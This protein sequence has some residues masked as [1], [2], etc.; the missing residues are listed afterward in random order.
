M[1]PPEAVLSAPVETRRRAR[2]LIIAAVL[3]GLVLRLAFTF[4]YWVGKPLTL[5]EQEYLLLASNAARGEGLTYPDAGEQ[6]LSRHFERP[7]VFS[8]L[9][10]A[11][12]R[13]T[14][15]PLVSAPRGDSG[16]PRG[17]PR[18]SSEV[19]VSVKLVQSL[20]GVAVIVLIAAL[21]GRAAGSGGAVAG[22]TLAAVYP[23]MVWLSGYVLSEAL[24]SALALGVVWLLHCAPRHDS[25][26]GRAPGHALDAAAGSDAG[27]TRASSRGVFAAG[28]LAGVAVL[29]KEHLVFF[30]PFAGFWLLMR[31]GL[32]PALVLT[33]GVALVLAPW[34][35]RNY[36]VH[37]R[38][39]LTASHGGVTFWTGNNPLAGGEGDLAANPEMGRARVAFEQ[40]LT[41]ATPQELDSAYYR[42]AF[43][44]IAANP[45]A[46]AALLA[47]KVFYTFVPI[48]RSYRLHSPRYFLTTL[49]SYGLVLALAVPGFAWLVRSRRAGRLTA[50]WLLALSTVA[51]FVVFFPQERFRIPVLDPA[52]V[53]GASA[54]L[55]SRAAV[56][57]LFSNECDLQG[58]V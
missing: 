38:F 18:S 53:V 56:S 19:P 20:I 52:L 13:L 12:F 39:V 46:W 48:G 43:R 24:Y 27:R 1:R 51:V 22:A 25:G 11:V 21:A 47:K 2:A 31:R 34:I 29:T 55:G 3:L 36:A 45:V 44:F 30:L 16:V 5:D 49:V 15:D 6:R 41:N 32:V 37:G 14:N 4:G 35:A 33:L 58:R 42:D 8:V 50:L 26:V 10:A 57:R 9:L 7:P 23:P 17:F 28:V 54:W 40:R